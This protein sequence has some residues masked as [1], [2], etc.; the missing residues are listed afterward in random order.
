MIFKQPLHIGE[1]VTCHAT[2]IN[3]VG[4]T[5]MDVGIKVVAENLATGENGTLILV[6]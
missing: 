5:S 2:I 1:L 4:R 6:V 3:Y